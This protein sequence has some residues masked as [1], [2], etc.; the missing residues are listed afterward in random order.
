MASLPTKPLL[1]SFTTHPRPA[2]IG[3]RGF[4]DVV[5]R[6]GRGV[7]RDGACLSRRGPIGFDAEGGSGREQGVPDGHRLVVRAEDSR[8]RLLPC[9]R[10][11]PGARG[12]PRRSFSRR[13]KVPSASSTLGMPHPAAD[14]NCERFRTLECEERRPVGRV[15]ELAAAL[16]RRRRRASKFSRR[17]TRCT[18]R[19]R[20][21][22][23][24]AIDDQVVEGWCR[25]RCNSTCRAALPS[26]SA[27][28]CRS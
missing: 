4:V 16:S 27:R 19:G 23:E 5:C 28:R 20:V 14:R 12:G 1:P 21:R 22:L 6:R 13:R 17:S 2:S 7:L 3:F 11:G 15:V 26:S 24:E 9:S 18:R 10:C 25:P 8:R